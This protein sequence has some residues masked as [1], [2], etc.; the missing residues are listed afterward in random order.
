MS[1]CS[2]IELTEM[3]ILMWGLVGLYGYGFLSR[4][5]GGSKALVASDSAESLEE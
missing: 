5:R 3:G 4:V 1:S 2:S